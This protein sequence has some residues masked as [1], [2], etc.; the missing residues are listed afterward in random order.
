ML[1]SISWNVWYFKITNYL[2]GDVYTVHHT[3]FYIIRFSMPW[4][5]KC[6]NLSAYDLIRMYRWLSI[7]RS[8]LKFYEYP[9]TLPVLVISTPFTKYISALTPSWKSW[10]NSLYKN[11]VQLSA[12]NLTR[13]NSTG[14][15]PMNVADLANFYTSSF[16]NKAIM[17]LL[18]TVLSNRNCWIVVRAL[19]NIFFQF[20]QYYCLHANVFSSQ[21]EN[22]SVDNF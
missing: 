6:W 5:E 15:I 20:W 13:E 21:T 17:S 9:F 14:A 16:V 10:A 4:A 8:L 3:V 1:R 12:G 22:F 7:R 19:A 11:K 18:L 2:K